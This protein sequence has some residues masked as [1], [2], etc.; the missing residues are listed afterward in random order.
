V[1]E[2]MFESNYILTIANIIENV[3]LNSS[4]CKSDNISMDF[5]NSKEELCLV[6]VPF[7]LFP[8][9]PTFFSSGG[10]AEAADEDGK[11]RD[12]IGDGGNFLRAQIPSFTY[13]VG[14]E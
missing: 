8:N 3:V 5:A 4:P 13:G 7:L 10:D 1:C 2:L 11:P 9:M 14:R 12:R 6:L